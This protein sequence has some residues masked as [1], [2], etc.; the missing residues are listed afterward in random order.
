MNLVFGAPTH[1]LTLQYM[2]LGVHLSSFYQKD[3]ISL[4]MLGRHNHGFDQ[5]WE[6]EKGQEILQ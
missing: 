1:I 2:A 6:G 3:P 5:D 4:Y